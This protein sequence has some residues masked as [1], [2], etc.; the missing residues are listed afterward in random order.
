M[1]EGTIFEKT[2]SVIGEMGT[3]ATVDFFQKTSDNRI[4]VLAPK[5]VQLTKNDELSSISADKALDY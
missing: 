5:V 2:I 4:A 1:I 3:L